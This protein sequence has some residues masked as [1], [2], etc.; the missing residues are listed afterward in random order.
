MRKFPK[1]E[2]LELIALD[3]DG[4]VMCPFGKAPVSERTRR[5][6]RAVTERGVPVTFVTGR[7]EDYAV[8][9]FR[10]MGL[11]T[12]MV[13][14]N[15]ARI[16]CPQEGRPLFE[17]AIER[18][19]GLRLLEWLEPEDEVACLYTTMDGSLHLLQNRSS[20][21]DGYDD[22]L[23]GVP[24]QVVGRPAQHLEGT[25][26][27]TKL[28]VVTKRDFASEF[29]SRFRDSAKLVRTHP[30]LVEIL[31]PGVSK[32]EGV[33]KLC[34]HLAIDPAKVLA[35]G[36]QENDVSTFE[37]C[38]YAVAMGDAPESVKQAA[39]FITGT[40]EE[41]GCAAALEKLLE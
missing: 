12:P 26:P 21:D 36:D 9:L 31:P 22:Y 1:I 14:Y 11:S 15:G 29:S 3:L 7:T 18:E 33:R 25:G 40:F 34:R 16:Y 5:A 37:L 24:R 13:T 39:D 35:V 4:T 2:D 8:S 20:G 38:G 10:E 23:F 28:I 41:D 6:V 17:A 27:I 32:G 30:E 19:V